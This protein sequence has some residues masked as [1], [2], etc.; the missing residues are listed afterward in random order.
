MYLKN[1]LGPTALALIVWTGSALCATAWG[2]DEQD[3]AHRSVVARI[4]KL[5]NLKAHYQDVEEFAAYP[6]DGPVAEALKKV[7]SEGSKDN[8]VFEFH[9]GRYKSDCTFAFLR[10]AAKL[11]EE[12]LQYGTPGTHRIEIKRKMFSTGNGRYEQ[13]I[14]ESP[15]GRM[16]GSIRAERRPVETAL[17]MG[18]G[19]RT[20]D[21]QDVMSAESYAALE[22]KSFDDGLL[23]LCRRDEKGDVEHEWTFDTTR[24]AAL[25]SY[26]VKFKDFVGLEVT[27]DDFVDIGGVRLPRRIRKL[28]FSKARTTPLERGAVSI[29]TVQV[30]EYNLNDPSQSED[31]MYIV[32]PVGTRMHDDR[33]GHTFSVV[34]KA[35]AFPDE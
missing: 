27:C 1:H 33:N 13:F 20:Y 24:G 3:A 14:Q 2:S 31:D 16:Q 7:V 11:E 22:Q 5:Q 19:L 26:A 28:R 17:E 25:T 34:D 9:T 12:Y 15:S 23:V 4:E 30:E 18:L 6:T 32:F 35:Q 10:G 8:L 21:S 29:D